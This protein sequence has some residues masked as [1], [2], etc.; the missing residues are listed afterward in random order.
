MLKSSFKKAASSSTVVKRARATIFVRNRLS[1]M[2][3][4]SMA[5]AKELGSQSLQPPSR[6]ASF[7]SLQCRHIAVRRAARASMISHCCSSFAAPACPRGRPRKPAPAGLSSDAYCPADSRRFRSA[8][9]SVLCCEAAACCAAAAS[10]SSSV[11]LSYITYPSPAS[12]NYSFEIRALAA[13][14]SK[15]VTSCF[16]YAAAKSSLIW[17]KRVWPKAAVRS[18]AVA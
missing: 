15:A 18:C 16:L 11:A 14:S 7:T 2:P 8:L 4:L 6:S 5:K 12:D 9:T 13:L 3:R 17:S 1:R 10:A